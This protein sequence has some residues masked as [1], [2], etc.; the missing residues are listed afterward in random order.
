MSTIT[1]NSSYGSSRKDR[2]RFSF[3]VR[4]FRPATVYPPTTTKRK[5]G[6]TE[7]TARTRSTNAHRPKK[8]FLKVGLVSA[9]TGSAYIEFGN[10]KVMCSVY[11]PRPLKIE[12]KVM[13][14]QL[15]DSGQMYSSTYSQASANKCLAGVGVRGP[16]AIFDVFLDRAIVQCDFTYTTFCGNGEGS[17]M[18][19]D[20]RKMEME[21]EISSILELII[22]KEKYPKSVI[23]VN[24]LILEDDGSAFTTTVNCAN[25]ALVQAGILMYDM[26]AACRVPLS[27]SDKDNEDTSSTHDRETCGSLHIAYSPVSKQIVHLVQLGES[28]LQTTLNCISTAIDRCVRIYEKM[29]S[30]LLQQLADHSKLVQAN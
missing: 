4:T 10:T 26:V 2:S 8:L 20:Q 9:A 23:Q 18:E 19:D 15:L 16:K 22:M 17:R 24:V 12:T 6:I 14:N 28:D 1:P 30:M 11:G 29:R 13:S 7:S 27:P 3:G 5:E 25:A 21:L